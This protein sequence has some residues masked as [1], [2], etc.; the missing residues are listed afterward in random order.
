MKPNAGFYISKINDIVTLTED[1]GDKLH[2]S[3]EVIRKAIDN[4]KL[5]EVSAEQ[6]T[7]INTEFS[8]GVATYN[9][10][11]ALIKTLKPTPRVM[12]IHKKFERAYTDYVAAC[13]AMVDSINEGVVDAKA[14]DASEVQQD[15]ASQ[16]ISF[17]I[18]RMTNLIMK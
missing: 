8:A 9:E 16:E 3:Y 5:S 12:G 2:E 4:D 11:L 10:Q 6:L 18:Q 17:A 13:Q 7:E 14:F 15:E 1:T